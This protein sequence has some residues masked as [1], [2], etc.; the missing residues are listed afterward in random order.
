MS[1]NYLA[2]APYASFVTRNGSFQADANALISN[3]GAGLPRK[4]PAPAIWRRRPIDRTCSPPQNAI[5]TPP[6]ASN[7][8]GTR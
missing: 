4:A 2:P 8:G 3:V 6:N 1:L 7:G 5:R